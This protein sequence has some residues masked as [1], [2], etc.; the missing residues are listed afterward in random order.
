M[1]F[2]AAYWKQ[3]AITIISAL[4]IWVIHGWYIDAQ[5]LPAIQ[6]QLK[7]EKLCTSGSQCAERL[8]SSAAEAD[9]TIKIALQKAQKENDD[10]QRKR[11]QAAKDRAEHDQQKL[12]ELNKKA[13][14]LQQ[15]F[16]KQLSHDDACQKWLTEVV[17]CV[18]Q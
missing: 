18:L 13:S 10:E 5:K 1:P 11:D 16:E 17:P 3:I 7:A 14:D 9:K 15:R 4:A 6:A 12:N 2:L 8:L